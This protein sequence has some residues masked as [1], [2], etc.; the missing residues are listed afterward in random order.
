VDAAIPAIAGSNVI[1][2]RPIP[3]GYAQFAF[4]PKVLGFKY[5]GITLENETPTIVGSDVILEQ[6]RIF[7]RAL[8]SFAGQSVA[9]HKGTPVISA[10]PTIAGQDIALTYGLSPVG[11]IDKADITFVGG[12]IAF[13]QNWSAVV[14]SVSLSLLAK[15][16]G[17]QWQADNIVNVDPA[18]FS[19]AGSDVVL[20]QALIVGSEALEIFPSS[21]TSLYGIFVDVEPDTDFTI[22]GSTIDLPFTYTLGITVD[23][24]EF[25]FVGGAFASFVGT[26][27]ILKSKVYFFSDHIEI[28]LSSPRTV[29]QGLSDKVQS[30]QS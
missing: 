17:L 25:A 10:T 8:P 11:Q 2:D 15:N 19:I 7:D 9:L 3:V 1:L 21:A 14:N 20:G 16:I 27:E 23:P 30:V 28:T 12:D 6:S 5:R 24:A 4:Q 13:Q 22:D 26:G 18:V 29:S